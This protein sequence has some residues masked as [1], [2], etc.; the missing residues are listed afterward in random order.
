MRENLALPLVLA[1]VFTA[2]CILIQRLEQYA[3]RVEDVLTLAF[4]IVAGL[5]TIALLGRYADG[6]RA[7]PRSP[8]SQMQTSEAP[9]LLLKSGIKG[10]IWYRPRSRQ[11][12]C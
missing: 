3:E 12:C 7:F 6:A 11:S 5:S 9:P 2:G 8:P 4:L 1:V 10:S